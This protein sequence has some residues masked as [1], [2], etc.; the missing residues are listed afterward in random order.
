MCAKRQR[1]ASD[2]LAQSKAGGSGVQV[3]PISRRRAA[4]EGFLG[5]PSPGLG[6][7]T[8]SLSA[9]L[10]VA[11]TQALASPMITIGRCMPPA[12]LAGAGG[13]ASL[14]QIVTLVLQD[15]GS[16]AIA[17]LRDVDADLNLSRR[18]LTVLQALQRAGGA[19][20]EIL[21][22]RDAL[23]QQITLLKTTRDSQLATLRQIALDT[24]ETYTG[25]ENAAIAACMIDNRHRRV[26][27]PLKGLDLSQEIWANLEAACR[28]TRR[29]AVLTEL[30]S[31]TLTGAQSSLL[32]RTIAAR[33]EANA[34]ALEAWM[35]QQI[36]T[37]LNGQP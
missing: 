20:S 24:V 35:H 15:T 28:K 14:A 32:V 18:D 34:P 7:C 2:E 11:G 13:T 22:R 12:A 26:P 17:T 27:E 36:V 19:T 10:L 6:C 30:E 4:R 33:I 9:F 21:E 37:A 5:L 16:A 29:G 31:T 1:S 8:A 23:V 3:L 25:S